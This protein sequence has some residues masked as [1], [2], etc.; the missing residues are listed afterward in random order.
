MK[1]KKHTKER[2]NNK[3]KPQKEMCSLTVSVYTLTSTQ[4]TL[5]KVRD[6]TWKVLHQIHGC[7]C[8]WGKGWRMHWGGEQ[9]IFNFIRQVEELHVKK[10]KKP[11]AGMAECSQLLMMRQILGCLQTFL[12]LFSSIMFFSK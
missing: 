11:E 1:K 8:L 9:S 12:H 5:C 6:A 4:G 10:K 3:S 7:V 2:K